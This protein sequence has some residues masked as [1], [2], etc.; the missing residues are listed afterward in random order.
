[1]SA[2]GKETPEMATPSPRID[3]RPPCAG[4]IA[5]GHLKPHLVPVP[6]APRPALRLVILKDIR[7]G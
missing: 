3:T 6:Q 5:A 7:H 4:H 1:M 2:P